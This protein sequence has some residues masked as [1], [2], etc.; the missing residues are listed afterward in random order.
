MGLEH[1]GFSLEYWSF[2]DGLI[3]S[4]T[5]ASKLKLGCLYWNKWTAQEYEA[6][7]LGLK[8][9]KLISNAALSPAVIYGVISWLKIGTASPGHQL[10]RSKIHVPPWGQI[11]LKPQSSFHIVSPPTTEPFTLAM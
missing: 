9:L 10:A 3:I 8:L 2:S 6:S 5:S 4:N 11:A 1:M 7:S